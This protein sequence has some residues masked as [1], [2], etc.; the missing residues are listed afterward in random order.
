MIFRNSIKSI[1][2]TPVKTVLFALLIA[3]VTAFLYLGVN[4]WTASVDMLRECDENCTT[5]V[6]MEYLGDSYPYEA[7]YDEG[8][9]NEVAGM[10]FGAIAENKNVLLWQPTELSIGI[11]E[12]FVAHSESMLYTDLCVLVVTKIHQFQENGPYYG[13]LV[14]DL[15]SYRGYSPGRA[16]YVYDDMLEDIDFVPDPNATYVLF[17]TCTPSGTS[18]EVQLTHFNNSMAELSGIDCDAVMPYQEIESLEEL[19]ADEDNIFLNIADYY[20][21]M[22]NKLYIYRTESLAELEEFNQNYMRVLSGRLFTSEEAQ[23]GAKLC[24]ISETLAN[25]R[26]LKVG[27]TLKLRMPEGSASLPATFF[28]GQR[29]TRQEGY[30]I[31]GI[32]SYY[33]GYQFN[34]YVPAVPASPQAVHYIYK[35]G[36]ATIKNGTADA[37][38]AQIKP[39]LPARVALSVYD[40]GYQ[41]TADSLFVIKKAAIALSLI[42]F[43]VTATVLAFFA[44]LFT[45]RQRGTVETMRCFGARKAETRLYLVLGASLIALIAVAA[46]IFTGTRFA[47]KLVESA[48]AFISELQAVDTRYSDGYLGITKGFTPVAALSVPL[49]VAAGASVFALS[50]GLCL[51]YA[52]RTVAGRLITAKAR[53]R[54]RRTPRR[55]STALSGPLRHA[56]LSIRRGGARSA[57]VPVLSAAMLLFMTALQATTASYGTARAALYDNTELQGYCATMYGKYSDT[58]YIENKNAKLLLDS[59]Y[60]GEITFTSQL[61]Y[62][63]L[64]I[65]QY[66]DGTPG[67][68]E[69]PPATSDP[70]VLEDLL[71]RLRSEPSLVF[72]NNIESAPEFY[73]SEFNGEFLPG[74]DASSFSRRDWTEPFCIVST[75]FM[76][77]NGIKLGDTIRVYVLFNYP[78]GYRAMEWEWPTFVALELKVVGSFLREAGQDNIYCPL[79][80]GALDPEH[81]TLNE[82]EYRLPPLLMGDY[83]SWTGG[84]LSALTPQQ[85]ADVLLDDKYVASFSFTLQ[86]PG[87]LSAFKDYLV[88]KGF[89]APKMRNG[90]GVFVIVEDSEFNDAVSALSQR[91]KY[92]QILYPVLLAL[93]CALGLITGFLVVN[94]RREDIALMRG[95]GTPKRRIFATIFG[96]QFLLLVLGALPAAAAWLALADGT[97]QL[98]TPGTFAF[99][100]CYALSAAFSTALQNGKSA[101]S[102]LSE[103]E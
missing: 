44:Y 49:A 87:E 17:G 42:A 75:L 97:Q 20:N 84:N 63:F 26:E 81:S 102:I 74:W 72:T 41:A 88:E 10:D 2:R 51:Y 21:V 82:L 23:A 48:Y 43:A 83:R 100:V 76:Q 12:G 85:L 73:F 15:Y 7:A 31:V 59:G 60:L 58:L 89:S 71:N 64:G 9:V 28:W 90:L 5:I 36:Q 79:P 57:I 65:S 1:L 16:V 47:Q 46:G 24:V 62:S 13:T 96:E 55:S 70:Y 35:L 34:V 32:V 8:M 95:M 27:D 52:Q 45:D 68:A 78:Y 54:G 66:A 37:F 6:T 80:L 50:L 22:S 18:L 40:Q 30:T 11:A 14:E 25:D 99:F 4:T 98:A 61:N 29:L 19:H 101:L 103:K 86:D 92:L 67:Q 69:E 39:L 77:N 33:E 38:L 53:T 93:V 3:A 94:S 56:V 91:I